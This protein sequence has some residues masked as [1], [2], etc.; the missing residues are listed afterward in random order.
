MEILDA[1]RGE[2]G[3][4]G[5]SGIYLYCLIPGQGE[6]V[7]EMS[8]DPAGVVAYPV[9]GLAA[10]CGPVC[11]DDFT[12]P[13]GEANLQDPQWLVP[14]A[15]RHEQVIEAV[16]AR[17]P[18]LPVRFGS[19]FSSRQ[20]LI[21]LIMAR[22]QVV[23]GFFERLG[24]REEWA[25]KGYLDLDKASDWLMHSDPVLADRQRRLP[26]MPGARY[27]HEKQLRTEVRKRLR[28]AGRELAAQLEAALGEGLMGTGSLKFREPGD[29][30]REMI[31]H[32]ACLV[33][34]EEVVRFEARILQLARC[35]EAQ[36]LILECSGPWPPYNFCPT[37]GEL[38]E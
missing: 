20:A 37:I 5:C 34:R 25:V 27:F 8:G 30:G 13:R 7:A 10:I 21:E 15:I 36:G 16:M 19:V 33:P 3:P 24:A 23:E 12:G 1:I 35:H 17:C 38:A 29:S 31:L 2:P 9:N 4:N 22:R 18:V 32:L 28:Q 6:G 14:R 11:L 26:A